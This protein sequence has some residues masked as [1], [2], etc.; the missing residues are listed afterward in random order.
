M[1]RE[2][3]LLE[4][5]HAAWERMAPLRQRRD[6]FRRFTYGDQWGDLVRDRRG[7]MVTEKE[8][9]TR[10]GREPLT[11]NLIRR[12][13][14]AVIGRFRMERAQNPDLLSEADPEG[15]NRLDELDARTLEEFL[16]SGMAIHRICREKRMAH[17]GVWADN[18]SPDRFFVNAFTD[19]R[20]CDLE[21]AGCLRDMSLPEVIM[22][23]SGGSP[24]RAA[25]L[26]TLY[27]ESARPGD[28][29]GGITQATDGGF[30]HAPEGRCRVIEIWTLESC[31]RL[32]CHDP[33][34]ATLS[35]LPVSDA[36]R[37]RRLNASRRRQKLPTVESRWEVVTL[38]HC[39]CLA[40]DGTLLDSYDSPLADGSLPFAIK[41]YPLVGGEV[42][43]LVEDVIDQ[44]KYVN[45]LI[46][47]MDHIMG[48]SAKGA[49][50]FP[51]QCRVDKF[52]WDV[53]A[54]IWAEPG[55]I[56]PYRAH[57]GVEPHQLSAPATD[58]GARDM[59]QTQIQ[60]F[61]DISGVNS[62]I[63]GKN[64]S[65][66]VGAQR[67]EA[68]MRNS[69]VSILDLMQTFTDFITTRNR[70]LKIA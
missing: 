43:S 66:A 61:E 10:A 36:A 20:G 28:V 57:D 47:L 60:L 26:R 23:F 59:L 1:T 27:A 64:L 5:A 22:R 38:W 31:E 40:P 53:Y 45:R 14:K 39:R 30:F 55:A 42:H 48:A 69:A 58:I 13:V 33:L 63:M 51:A 9:A 50:L 15:F 67:Y 18:I 16:I 54:N 7:R 35:H 37:L 2:T 34:T 3:T 44:Q 46:S 32:R 41:M 65:G 19:I 6:R 68:E 11:N 24:E 56:I 8:A 70:L 21:M 29:F 52:D 12:L 49:L 4:A 17:A 25:Q 62:A